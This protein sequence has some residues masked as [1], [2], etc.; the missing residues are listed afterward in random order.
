MILHGDC[1]AL[2]Q[3]LPDASVDMAYLDPPF[4]TNRTYSATTRDRKQVFSFVDSWQNLSEYA[5]LMRLRLLEVHRVLKSTASVFVH[6]DKSANFLPRVLLDEIF[7]PEQFCSEIIWTYKRW[8]NAAKGLLLLLLERI[9]QLVTDPDDLVLD[10]FCGSGT[11]LVAAALLGRKHIGIDESAEAVRLSQIRLENPE[12][13]ESALLKNGRAA[14]ETANQD[15]LELLSGLD[16]LPV[17]RNAGIDAFLRHKD[18]LIPIRVQRPNESL[19][20]AADT[21]AKAAY[22]KQFRSGIVVKTTPS[23]QLFDELELPKMVV[24][25]DAIALQI[26][27]SL[28]QA[29]V[30]A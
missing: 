22:T 12:K 30:Y 16:I 29:A 17:Q 7:S 15:A 1:L 3:T 8:S 9:I 10:P 18:G 11:T 6:C 2:L 13:T 19:L 24:V 5:E 21:L 20:Y 27:R 28:E 25:V 23:E 26:E 4:F 14:F